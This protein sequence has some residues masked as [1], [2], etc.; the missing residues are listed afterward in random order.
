M[1]KNIIVSL[2]IAFAGA[3]LLFL[4]INLYVA[5]AFD[6]SFGQ[7]FVEMLP[8]YLAGIIAIL[9]GV[10]FVYYFAKRAAIRRAGDIAA[11]LDRG[12]YA[13]IDKGGE[14]KY[15]LKVL[16]RLLGDK[17]NGQGKAISADVTAMGD[18]ERLILDNIDSGIIIM[19]SAT[20]VRLI[21]EVATSIVGY[22]LGKELFYFMADTEFYSVLE[23]KENAV[24]YKQADG[25]FYSFKISFVLNDNGTHTIVVVIDDVSK[26]KSSENTKN[27]FIT[28][29]THEMNTPL[30]SIAGY[31]ELI[32][33]GLDEKNTKKSAE[34]I[35]TQSR[36]LGGL[37]KSIMSYSQIDSVS[38]IF[39]DVDLSKS[40]NTIVAHFA[41]FEHDN[42]VTIT[43]QIDDGVSVVSRHEHINELLNNLISN[44][45]KY[46][47]QGGKVVVSLK[48]D[49]GELIIE[50]TGIGIDK[51]NLDRI[52]DRFYKVD[53]SHSGF[54]YGLG[55]SIVK[56]IIEKNRWNIRVDS[57]LGQWTRVVVGFGAE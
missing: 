7:V 23:A 18:N 1:K 33:K 47:K 53:T 41:G 42:G 50:D 15:I 24:V 5:Y 34:T 49:T 19:D 26:I 29:I 2:A 9:I 46:N 31:A 4:L 13:S 6:S 22:K 55:L 10:F 39:Y 40:A 56:K 45:I 25:I 8:I 51:E 37:V 44:A 48:K 35:I 16:G 12:E 30:T 38:G 21:N 28:N 14:F 3:V 52:F 54:G 43:G 32:K 57:Q 11:K 36:R 20:S 27:E 17:S